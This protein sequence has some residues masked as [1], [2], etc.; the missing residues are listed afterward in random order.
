MRLAYNDIDLGQVTDGQIQ[1]IRD[2]YAKDWAEWPANEGALYEDVDGDGTYNPEMISRV[3]LVLHKPFLSNMMTELL[4]LN[5]VLR[6]LV[7]KYP[8]TI[9]HM[10]I[11]VL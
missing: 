9:G 5:M 6:L 8:H 3:S 7:W 2:Q 4:N 11:L 10:L 1:E